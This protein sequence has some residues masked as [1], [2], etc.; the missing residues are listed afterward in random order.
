M[1]RKL[2]HYLQ[3]D[4]IFSESEHLSSLFTLS[5]TEKKHIR[6]FLSNSELMSNF[7][8]MDATFRNCAYKFK[9][10]LLVGKNIVGHICAFWHVDM[11]LSYFFAYDLTYF[12]LRRTI[13]IMD[14]ITLNF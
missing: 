12:F 3:M 1:H 7:L 14:L 6:L 10:V 9:K 8:L 5:I 4:V 11:D 2:E 13:I